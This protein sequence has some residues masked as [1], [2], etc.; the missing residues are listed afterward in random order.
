[1]RACDLFGGKV[2][3]LTVVADTARHISDNAVILSKKPLNKSPSDRFYTSS[4]V[5]SAGVSH[6]MYLVASCDEEIL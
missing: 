6:L 4:L 5:P 1:M 2:E 3:G